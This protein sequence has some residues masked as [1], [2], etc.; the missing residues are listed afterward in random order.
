[1][2][3]PAISVEDLHI[4]F[5]SHE[6]LRGVSFQIKQGEFVG[7]VGPNGSGKS[8]LVKAISKIVPAKSGSIQLFGQSIKQIGYKQI[9]HILGV[10]PQEQNADIEYT[11]REIVMMGRTPHWAWLQDE[12]DEDNQM[13][14]RAMESAGISHLA[15]R[16]V[17]TL[18][19]GEKQRV[20]I[21]Q[22]IAQSPAMVVLDEPIANLDI[23]FQIIIMDMLKQLNR[24]SG[25]AVAVVLHDLNIASQYAE[26]VFVMSKGTIVAVGTPSE[27]MTEKL[28]SKVYECQ[29]TVTHHPLSGTPFVALHPGVLDFQFGSKNADRQKYHIHII[30]G[31]G[32]GRDILIPLL[33]SGYKLSAGVLNEGDSDWVMC[34][35]FGIEVVSETPFSAISQEKANENMDIAKSADLILVLPVPIGHGNLANIQLVR[36]IACAGIPVLIAEENSIANRDFTGGKALEIFDSIRGFNSVFYCQM[37][38]LLNEL[39]WIFERKGVLHE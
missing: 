1:M 19:G 5:G 37:T 28:I 39:N 35:K 7:I 15:S 21:S 13:V 18:S 27:V 22:V 12:S 25:I 32:S 14:D 36:E 38:I 30:M 9:A 31:G 23:H 26:R 34:E 29:V 10:V 3:N 17:S 6:V 20:F 4:S 16:R 11:V 8:T 33:Y 24:D 2:Q